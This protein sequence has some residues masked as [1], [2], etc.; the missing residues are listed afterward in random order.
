VLRSST[1]KMKRSTSQRGGVADNAHLGPR[2]G[3]FCR[4]S[5]RAECPFISKCHRNSLP[6]IVGSE[7]A[8]LQ[9]DGGGGGEDGFELLILTKSMV[10]T[11]QGLSTTFRLNRNPHHTDSHIH[12]LG[13]QLEAP[14]AILL[15][16]PVRA[17][18]SVHTPPPMFAL[19]FQPSS[20][21]LRRSKEQLGK[22]QRR[23][24]PTLSNA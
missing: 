23:A 13:I 16:V 10:R 3:R 14:H 15:L 18:G 7:W 1:T 2:G 22:N 8:E 17:A 20:A 4:H 9:R 12:A 19:R 5:N 11:R 24:R 21:H 6:R